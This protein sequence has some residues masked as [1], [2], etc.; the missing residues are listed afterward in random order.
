MDID[1]NKNGNERNKLVDKIRKK[2]D[3]ICSVEENIERYE[4][5]MG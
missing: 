5:K 4:N 3:V 1:K 2:P